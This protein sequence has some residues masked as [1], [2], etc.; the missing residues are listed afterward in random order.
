M[1]GSQFIFGNEIRV[2]LPLDVTYKIPERDMHAPFA[3]E[4]PVKSDNLKDWA[5]NEVHKPLL[6]TLSINLS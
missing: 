3:H 5:G 4:P 2:A 6:G 1:I